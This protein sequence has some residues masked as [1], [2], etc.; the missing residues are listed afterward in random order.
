VTD[1]VDF[2]CVRADH[3][4]GTFVEALTIHD[5]RWAYCPS[6]DADG[7]EWRACEAMPADELER[8]LRRFPAARIGA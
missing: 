2:V 8:L 6:A 3:Q 1:Q 7:H 4:I 5:E